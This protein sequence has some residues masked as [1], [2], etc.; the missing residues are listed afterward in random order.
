MAVKGMDRL[1]SDW[2]ISELTNHFSLV[3]NSPF[4]PSLSPLKPFIY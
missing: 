2:L 3:F 4:L 1:T